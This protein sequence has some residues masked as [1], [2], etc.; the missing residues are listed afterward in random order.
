MSGIDSIFAV[1]LY[2]LAISGA[3]GRLQLAVY[4]TVLQQMVICLCFTEFHANN[5]SL[6]KNIKVSSFQFTEEISH[7][8]YGHFNKC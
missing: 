3:E 1:C 4:W 6:F 8:G 5:N 2:L 7:C